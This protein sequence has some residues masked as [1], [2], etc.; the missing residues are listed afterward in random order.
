MV[1]YGSGEVI[2]FDIIIMEWNIFLILK[3]CVYKIL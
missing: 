3:F 1:Y 2:E